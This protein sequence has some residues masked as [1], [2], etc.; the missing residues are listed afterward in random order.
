L[1]REHAVLSA[2]P[3]AGKTV[4]HAHADALLSAQDRPDV[5]LRAGFDQGI[6]RI[7]GK[8]RR[9]LA[10]EDFRNDIGPLHGVPFCKAFGP[11]REAASRLQA[12]L[13]K[14]NPVPVPAGV[15]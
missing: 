10:P 1:G 5:E 7:A 3:D 8:K 6:A 11:S 4:R 2:A 14:L 12:Q 13:A 9:P 15:R